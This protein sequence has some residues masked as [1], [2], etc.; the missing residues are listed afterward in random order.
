MIDDT[1]SGSLSAQ[2]L[3]KLGARVGLKWNPIEAQEIL[4]AC[5][6][7]GNGRVDKADFVK[8]MKAA[9]DQP[10]E[11][12]EDVKIG[13][14]NEEQAKLAARQAEMDRIQAELDA[15][16]EGAEPDVALVEQLTRLQN[17]AEADRLRK[18]LQHMP[19]GE[20]H[21]QSDARL[22]ELLDLLKVEEESEEQ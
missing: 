14:S 3:Q 7:D 21:A 9:W 8:V 2:Q 22:A 1:N 16:P 12:W 6:V 5:D 18:A 13:R 17:E 15:T 10:Q 19:D 20:E 11:Q 4:T